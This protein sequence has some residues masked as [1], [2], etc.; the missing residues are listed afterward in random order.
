MA[1]GKARRPTG[2]LDGTGATIIYVA[3]NWGKKRPKKRKI[4]KRAKRKLRQ[5]LKK[6]QLK[7]FD[8]TLQ[9]HTIC[10]YY[11]AETGK[12]HN[13]KCELIF[14]ACEGACIY[15]K[16]KPGALINTKKKPVNPSPPKKTKSKPQARHNYV[17]GPTVNG[18]RT[19][20][21]TWKK[22]KKK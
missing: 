9:D 17:S 21:F 6:K 22:K 18:K 15:W 20:Y 19:V 11:E 10:K 14:P 4:S 8:P 13:V 12:C 2:R 16:G 5:R 7:K 1:I 3:T